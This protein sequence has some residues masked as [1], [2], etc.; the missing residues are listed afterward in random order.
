MPVNNNDLQRA[1]ILNRILE[2]TDRIAQ[3]STGLN[4]GAIQA[5][6]F[7]KGLE[8]IRAR[9]QEATGDL[10]RLN[11]QLLKVAA[12]IETANAGRFRLGGGERVS[13]AQYVQPYQNSLAQEGPAVLS[14]REAEA[15]R[16]ARNLGNAVNR[17][18]PPTPLTPQQLANQGPYNIYPPQDQG[19]FR[20]P[21]LPSGLE[22]QPGASGGVYTTSL[23][24]ASYIA[25]VKNTATVQGQADIKLQKAKE[26]AQRRANLAY[27]KQPQ[28]TQ[29]DILRSQALEGRAQSDAFLTQLQQQNVGIPYTPAS[30]T[31]GMGGNQQLPQRLLDILQQQTQLQRP[32]PQFPPAPGSSWGGLGYSAV[33]NAPLTPVMSEAAQMSAMGLLP[34][35]KMGNMPN[36]FP[37]ANKKAQYFGF[38]PED[39]RSINTEASSGIS[40][41]N[42]QSIDEATGALKNL[43]LTVDKTGN[44][45]V[46]TQKRFRDFFSEVGR[47]T[48]EFLKWSLA[49]SL[50]LGPLQKFGELVQTAIENESKLADISVTL[51]SG[52]TSV[53]EVFSASAE[54]ANKAGEEINTV[55]DAYQ[56]AYRAIGGAADPTTRFAQANK[57]L[58]DSM[59]LSKLTGMDEAKAIDTLSAALR[60]SFSGDGALGKGTQLLDKWVAT[61]KVA[62][63]DLETLATGFAI[64]GDAADAAGLSVDRLNGLLAAIAETGVASGKEVA[65]AARAI[66]SGFQSDQAKKL[67]TNLGVA[68]E[69]NGEARSFD[70]IV[71]QLAQMRVAGKAGQAGGL[72]DEQFNKLTLT[73]GGG[74]RRQ[75]VWTTLIENYA[76]VGE[77][78]ESSSKASGDA[79]DAMTKK[80]AITQTAITRLGNAFQTLANNLGTKGGILDDFKLLVE[81]GTTLVKLF[82]TL[83]SV[84][85]KA[86][87]VAIAGIGAFGLLAGKSPESKNAFSIGGLLSNVMVPE[88]ATQQATTAGRNAFALEANKSIGV[89]LASGALAA[90]IPVLSNAQDE[91]LT[92]TEKAVKIGGDIVGGVVGGLVGGGYGAIIGVTIAES[93][94]SAIIAGAN[95]DY[96]GT[97]GTIVAK[98][99]GRE[100]DKQGNITTPA[101][102]K[103]L[104]AQKGLLSTEGSQPGSISPDQMQERITTFL[105]E[106][107][108][109]PFEEREQ[110]YV[111]QAK[112]YGKT[113]TP[114]DFEQLGQEEV[115]DY[116]LQVTTGKI[117][118]RLQAIKDGFTA[119]ANENKKAGPT[120]SE[121]NTFYKINQEIVDTA[122]NSLSANV[123]KQFSEG[124]INKSGLTR[125]LTASKNL[126]TIGTN[127]YQGFGQGQDMGQFFEKT[128]RITAFGS[129][130]DISAITTYTNEIFNY[131][132]II[133][134]ATKTDEE[135]T[136]AIKDKAEALKI[137]TTLFEQNN[138]AV[139]AQ[140]NLTPQTDVYGWTNAQEDIN[141]KRA[142]ELQRS[143]Y[144]VEVDKGAMTQ[145]E[146]DARQREAS[147]FLA[148]LSDTNYRYYGKGVVE[149]GFY[150]QARDLNV[151][152]GILP[153]YGKDKGV[154][155]QSYDLKSSEF[156]KLLTTEFPKLMNDLVSKGY[157]EE[158]S[159]IIPVLNDK[160]LPQMQLDTKVM[161]LLLQQIADNTKGMS[162]EFNLPEGMSF[163]IPYTWLSNQSKGTGGLL[164]GLGTTPT[165]TPTPSLSSL[166]ASNEEIKYQEVHADLGARGFATQNYNWENYAK[167]G[168]GQ[169]NPNSEVLVDE[170][171]LKAMNY[172]LPWQYTGGITQMAGTG[173]G[174]GGPA[175]FSTGDT[176]ISAITDRLN[177]LNN[178][179]QEFAD[180][181]INLNVTTTSVLTMDSKVIGEAISRYIGIK[182]SALG[183]TYVGA[184]PALAF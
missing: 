91:T 170:D 130:E 21:L 103:L 10:T 167:L 40:K 106:K 63:V 181:P 98:L 93:F 8:M 151:K 19:K 24:A 96:S 49:V 75:A 78:A 30:R 128:G 16:R 163:N 141:L 111:Q 77:V 131:D 143:R 5:Q 47:N 99:Q 7:A 81:F 118:D 160:I 65:N 14:Q 115:I 116:A 41:L 2:L 132:K 23:P 90:A 173:V 22:G 135:H 125:G 153:K 171:K 120:E 25:G 66:I 140:K 157:K 161:S 36:W 104:D 180:R 58:S 88:Q 172:K 89:K 68:T 83:S 124:S 136:K 112:M 142:R 46:D 108:R 73:L 4:L 154:Q 59:V 150:E 31:M 129:E 74:S 155:I 80:T 123:F 45:L 149:Q 62:N 110:A 100:V 32:L 139:L 52:Q 133:N 15:E 17:L 37:Q 117:H 122:S 102:Q 148:Q 12:S 182:L 168:M 169:T 105:S 18:Y 166:S 174:M 127:W 176:G 162:G 9:A 86:F 87:P 183:G 84:A 38:Q 67:L 48:V 29:E 3:G 178:S 147:P 76:R 54:I 60:Q 165:T 146:A 94:T 42:Y 175:D 51:A 92:D 13:T 50:V 33:A 53:A 101:Q 113:Y 79:Q 35:G 144:A 85:G 34:M 28:Y 107:V 64:V 82:D 126:N 20:Y 114:K 27:A 159:D 70:D 39:L 138:Q 6:N 43:N 119:V 134:D 158:K 95:R 179:L 44:V 145:E 56:I 156:S 26:E 69:S 1:E 11:Q 71:S 57:L 55:L 109:K 152:E 121:I 137:V 164:E 72:T 61:T 184:R 97:W 177:V